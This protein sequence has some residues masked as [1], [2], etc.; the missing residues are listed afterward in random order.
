MA[1]FMAAHERHDAAA[2]AMLRDDIRLTMPP[3][4]FLIEGVDVVG[5]ALETA[6]GVEEVGDWRL[7]PTRANRMPAAASYLRE[8]GDARFRAFKIDL[9]RFV[10]GKVAEVT[11]FGSS[12][13][14][15]FGLPPVLDE[16]GRRSG[17]GLTPARPGQSSW[18]IGKTTPS[19]Q[20]AI[21][22]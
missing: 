20:R 16:D 2:A 10:D 13:F 14:P 15:R 5:P 3:N 17:R 21:E 7:V 6:F 1:E 18:S 4:P 11:T 12:L 8:W 19:G 22:R 9:V